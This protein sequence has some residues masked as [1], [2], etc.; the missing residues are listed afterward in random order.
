LTNFTKI[1]I[2]VTRML[3]MMMGYDAHL[4]GCDSEAP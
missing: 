4:R 1:G 3:I 2:I